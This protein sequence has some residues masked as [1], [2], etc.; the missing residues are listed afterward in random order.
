[1]AYAEVEAE[2]A[3][4]TAAFQTVIS[5]GVER[6]I[7]AL[8]HETVPAAP[9][10]SAEL[11]ETELRRSTLLV[12]G[13]RLHFVVSEGGLGDETLELTAESPSSLSLRGVLDFSASRDAPE[14]VNVDVALGYG[15]RLFDG[16]EFENAGAG[17]VVLSDP[18]DP[19]LVQL[20]TNLGAAELSTTIR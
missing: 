17:S 9:A 2:L 5:L 16:I 6:E 11:P 13:V 1:V 20:S 8:A 3:G 18:D 14:R 4:G 15:A 12:R 10:P 7:D 19:L